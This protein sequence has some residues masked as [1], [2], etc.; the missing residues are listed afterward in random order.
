[1]TSL[2]DALTAVLRDPPDA[3]V[4][5][6]SRLTASKVWR[7]I[8]EAAGDDWHDA[9]ALNLRTTILREDREALKKLALAIELYE[10]MS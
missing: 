7:R 1:M 4:E 10:A 2:A 9:T 8:D 5:Q 6:W 3:L